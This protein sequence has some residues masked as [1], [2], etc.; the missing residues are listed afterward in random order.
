MQTLETVRE[1]TVARQDDRLPTALSGPD[2]NIVCMAFN[3]KGNTSLAVMND[4]NTKIYHAS[5]YSGGRMYGEDWITSHTELES[6]NP[7]ATRRTASS[8][9]SGSAGSEWKAI[10]QVYVLRAC[11]LHPWIV[12]VASYPESWQS[13]LEIMKKEIAKIIAT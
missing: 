13:Y 7:T 2:F 6:S 3:F 11:V 5:S 4:L 12:K 8:S 1:F 9:S 10:G